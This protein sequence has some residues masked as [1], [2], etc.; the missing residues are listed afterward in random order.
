MTTDYF[1]DIETVEEFHALTQSD[2][3]LPAPH[4]SEELPLQAIEQYD[5][6]IAPPQGAVL[7]Q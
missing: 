3:T 6:G 4:F 1:E 5:S 7:E 2:S